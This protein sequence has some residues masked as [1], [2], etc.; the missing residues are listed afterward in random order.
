M[1]K[2]QLIYNYQILITHKYWHRP[3]RALLEGKNTTCI[4]LL[5]KNILM[6][7]LK[8]KLVAVFVLGK[9]LVHY[10]I[11]FVLGLDATRHIDLVAE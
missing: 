10:W 1:F 9:K 11:I 6:N 4:N 7:V 2:Y 8:F 3:S 5:Y